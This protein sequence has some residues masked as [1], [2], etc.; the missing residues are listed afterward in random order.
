MPQA[1]SATA[2]PQ[3][4]LALHGV[5][6]LLCACREAGRRPPAPLPA[7]LLGFVLA[8]FSRAGLRFWARWEGGNRAG[9]L[10]KEAGAGIQPPGK[11]EARTPKRG[12]GVR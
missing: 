11:R 2:S 6:P 1:F 3:K 7:R 12:E 9:P 10:A 4:L 8:F 5:S